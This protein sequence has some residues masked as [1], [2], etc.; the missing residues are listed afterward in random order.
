[1]RENE[2]SSLEALFFSPFLFG[3][4]LNEAD[5]Q[6]EASLVLRGCRAML[7]HWETSLTE[8][9]CS[10]ACGQRHKHVQDLGYMLPPTERVRSC[11]LKLNLHDNN[12]TDRL[13]LG[14]KVKSPTDL[15]KIKQTSCMQMKNMHSWEIRYVWRHMGKVSM[16]EI[17]CWAVL[18]II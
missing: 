11:S 9:F 12:E 5:A 2:R 3:F 15:Q 1:M 8:A 6:K 7:H 18:L 10:C 17:L 13:N 4:G 16:A 14:L